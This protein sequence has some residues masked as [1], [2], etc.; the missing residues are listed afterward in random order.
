MIKLK[1]KNK[2]D[3]ILRSRKMR[4]KINGFT[5]VELLVVIAIIAV[6]LTILTPVLKVARDQAKM[7]NC[8]VQ[9]KGIGVGVVMYITQNDDRTHD[10]PNYGLW[11]DLGTGTGWT[12]KPLNP[13]SG[14]AYWGVAYN[15]Y[16][17][18][19]EAFRCPAMMTIDH[20]WTPP[21][22]HYLFENSTYGLNGFVANKK[23]GAFE[24]PEEVI[25]C[26]DHIEQRQDVWS[27]S[28]KLCQPPT[29]GWNLYEWRFGPWPATWPEAERECFRH[30]YV[31]SLRASHLSPSDNPQFR[32]MGYC[33]TLWLD[34]HVSALEG[35]DGDDG[36]NI[37]PYWY[38]PLN[39]L[40]WQP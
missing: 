3:F 32:G 13:N 29:G 38:D 1:Y 6:L 10:S 22:E 17:E 7:A 2:T 28:D 19:E 15:K 12:G 39:V 31:E 14:W 9:L 37:S 30:K 36:A 40:N 8:A 33:N 27:F 21:A 20:W 26:Q 35:G 11:V 34:G 16:V 25:F 23:V 24:H 18:E 5:L 4:I